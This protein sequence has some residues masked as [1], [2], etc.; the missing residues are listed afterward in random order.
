MAQEIVLDPERKQIYKQT[1]EG[2]QVC[3]LDQMIRILGVTKDHQKILLLLGDRQV[4][5]DSK[6]LA[7][8]NRFCELISPEPFHGSNTDLEKIKGLLKTDYIESRALELKDLSGVIGRHTEGKINLWILNDKILIQDGQ[9]W[10]E[11]AYEG[12]TSIIIQDKI[13]WIDTQKVSSSLK[14]QVLPRKETNLSTQELLEKWESVYNNKTIL[15]AV[16]G[17]FIACMYMPEVMKAADRK[18]FPIMAI[19]GTTAQ[20]KT[21]LTEL[22]YKFWGVN[23]S[24]SPYTQTSPFVETK[25][26]CAVGCFPIWRDEYRNIGM[27]KQKEHIL[28]SLYDRAP[29]DKG[30]ASQELLSYMPKTTLFLTGEDVMDDPAVRRRFVVFQLSLVD[31]LPIKDWVEVST[32][33]EEIFSNL[34]FEVFKKGFNGEI[35]KKV[36]EETLY[37][38]N[39]EK[40]EKLL[41]A[42][43]GAVFGEEYGR[44]AVVEASEFWKGG[45]KNETLTTQINIVDSFFNFINALAAENSWFKGQDFGQNRKQAEIFKYINFNKLDGTVRMYLWGLI[46]KA[47]KFGF[48]NHSNLGE[49]ALRDA[50]GAMLRGETK[51][52]RFDGYLSKGVEFKEDGDFPESLKTFLENSKLAYEKE[53]EAE[54]EKMAKQRAWAKKD[55]VW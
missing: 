47:F 4:L 24:S 15:R 20:G 16:L 44:K 52:I 27:A 11:K 33:G 49:R 48:G 42:T 9:K 53:I 28:R 39:A 19:F 55:N 13:Y 3:L 5:V 40:E 38:D 2:V 54:A 17:Y 35:F 36:M 31:K 50:V 43:L 7:S 26:V 25:Q 22:L 21:A 29:I 30:T 10:E 23:S 14:L 41:Y 46:G 45:Q 18:N 8:K 12:Q 51:N 32:E 37:S 34:F 6:V 1:G